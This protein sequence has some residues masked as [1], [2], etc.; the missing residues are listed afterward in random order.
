MEDLKKLDDEIVAMLDTA[1]AA[2]NELGNACYYLFKA[3]KEKPPIGA[4][5]N[6]LG[7]ALSHVN[8]ARS[9][10]STREG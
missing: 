10:L 1:E 6:L 4:L 5:Q 2:A 8:N 3:L 9:A 7:A